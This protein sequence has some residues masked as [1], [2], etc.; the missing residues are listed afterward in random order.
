VK[1]YELYFLIVEEFPTSF[2]SIGILAIA[3]S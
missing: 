3:K 1:K 2:P